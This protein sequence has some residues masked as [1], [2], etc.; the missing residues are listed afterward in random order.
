MRNLIGALGDAAFIEGRGADGGEIQA[1]LRLIEPGGALAVKLREA[2]DR[3]LSGLFGFSID[4]R[5][6]VR[7]ARRAGRTVREATRFF[8]I[9]SVDLIVEPGAGGGITDLIEAKEDTIMTREQI[10]ALL[11]AKGL[12]NN[13]N[14][15]DL[16]DEALAAMLREAV[17]D[18]N[19]ASGND[20]SNTA[21]AGNGNAGLTPENVDARIAE[22]V[23]LTEARGTARVAIAASGLPEAAQERLIERLAEAADVPAGWAAGAIET[24]R[25]Y[26][27][28]IAGGGQVTGLGDPG[29]TRI[30]ESRAEKT[31]RMLDA[32]LDPNDNSMISVKEAYVQST[33]D[34]RVTGLVRECDQALMR[35]ALTSTSFGE[36]LGDSITRRMI[37]DYRETGIYDIWM[38]LV[39]IVPVNDF[40]TQRRVRWGGYGDLPVV[41]EG[42]AYAA[43][44]SPRRRGGDLRGHQARAPSRSRWR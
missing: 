16:D 15:E 2:W 36:A 17:A 37:A 20:R 26:L 28:G 38:R 21:A 27:A 44:T 39:S 34:I 43:L 6:A 19:D 1:T 14:A 3:G 8:K 29:R 32:L 31:A 4:A 5:A 42:G 11:E 40:R 22:A 12:L 7:H 13:V 9:N 30:T 23:R 35:E 33:G 25:T 41:A 18:A 10:I 24:E